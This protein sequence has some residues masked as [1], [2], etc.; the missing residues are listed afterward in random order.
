MYY[1]VM[2]EL[3][4]AAGQRA[5]AR[6]YAEKAISLLENPSDDFEFYA[7][8]VAYEELVNYDVALTNLDKA[9]QYDDQKAIAY[10]RR[11]RVYSR[12]G[13]FDRG[14]ADF[15]VEAAKN[16][17]FTPTLLAGQPVKVTGV[18]HYNFVAR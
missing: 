14:L 1:A 11:G 17:L 12:K 5:Q 15:A 4:S 3:S 10:I 9:I 13:N 2:C 18:I 8:G 16:S 7:K 6:E